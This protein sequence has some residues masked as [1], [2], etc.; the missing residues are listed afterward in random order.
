MLNKDDMEW[1]R[2]GG[3][4]AINTAE[5]I[6]GNLEDEIKDL[7]DRIDELEETAANIHDVDELNHKLLELSSIP[8]LDRL[9]VYTSVSKEV[10]ILKE[11]ILVDCGVR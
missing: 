8:P 3:E 10:T 4:E 11:K 9:G 2:E 5:N 6:I 7:T 1:I